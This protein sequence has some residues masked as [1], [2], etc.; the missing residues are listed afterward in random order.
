MEM[1]NSVSCFFLSLLLLFFVFKIFR[2]RIF[3]KNL[4]PSPL[5]L[6]VIGHFHLLKPRMYRSLQNLSINYGPIFSLRFGHRL[7]IVVSS[8]SAV[9]ECFTKNDVV[10][11]N[12]PKFQVGK[13][14]SYNNTTIPQSSYGDHW[15]NLRRI[16]AVEVFSNARLNK[17]LSIRK[18]EIKRLIIKLSHRSSQDFAKVELRSLFKELT[19]NMIVRMITG[20]RYYGDDVGDKEE[21]RQFRA[22]IVEVISY[23]GASNPRDFLPILNWIDGGRFEKKLISMGKRTDE[24]VQRLVDEHR[25]KKDNSESRNTMIDHLLAL[26]ETEPD[27][28][29][30]EIIKGLAVSMIFAGTDTSAVTL[31]WAMSN[32]LNN[33]Q[34]L[35]KARDEIDTQVGS[36]CLLDEPHVSKLPYLQNIFKETLRLYPAAPLLGAHEAS[37]DCTIGGYDVPR[38]TIVLVNAWAMHRDP[39]LWDDPLKFKPERFD[40]GGGEGFNTYKFTPFGTGRR[41]CPG[42]GLAQRIVCLALG[43]LIQCFEWKRVTDEEIDMTEGRGLTMPKLEPLEAMCKAR[44]IA[45]K[46][47]A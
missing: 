32:L 31:E 30:D 17:F 18:D 6:P 19:F 20:K 13:Y 26:Q 45:K 7:V 16:V 15:R 1:D 25:N 21:A 22:L 44:P 2:S 42:A 27:H 23:A 34:A 43:T 37:D 8:P 41:A 11:A 33:Q 24:F 4:P 38:G 40:N 5:A 14:I 46:I 47:V 9:E 3:F 36:E 35:M 39:T 10:L 28:H 29:T 12:R